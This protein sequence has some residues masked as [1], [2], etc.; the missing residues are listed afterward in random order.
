MCIAAHMGSPSRMTSNP[1]EIQTT[2]GTLR[3][4]LEGVGA[5]E[6]TDRPDQRAPRGNQEADSTDVERG[7]EKIDRVLG[8]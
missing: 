1:S 7:Q 3:D 5:D 2:P 4:E 8:W 6:R